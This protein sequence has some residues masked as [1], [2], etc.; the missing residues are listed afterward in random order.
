MHLA[1]V[2]AVNQTK[3]NKPGLVFAAVFVVVVLILVLRASQVNR[4]RSKRA[5]EYAREEGVAGASAPPLPAHTWQAIAKPDLS[6][7]FGL[8]NAD[9]A[10]QMPALARFAVHQAERANTVENVRSTAL[11]N[12]TLVVFDHLQEQTDGNRTR[13]VRTACGR[14]GLDLNCPWLEVSANEGFGTFVVGGSRMQSFKFESD[15]FN[16]AF[17]VVGADQKFAFSLLDGEMMLWLLAHPHLRS[18]HIQGAGALDGVHTFGS[19]D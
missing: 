11:A 12:T 6:S 2:T 1:L 3:V 14:F 17:S 10:A 13:T 9:I 7:L 16:Q 8:P 15:D 19:R 5:T 4:R 18:L